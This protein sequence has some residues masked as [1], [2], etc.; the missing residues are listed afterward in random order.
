MNKKS[1]TG[2]LI[3]SKS[4]DCYWTYHRLNLVLVKGDKNKIVIAHQ[5]DKIVILGN[6]NEIIV[7]ITG[8]IKEIN[9][10]GNNNAIFAKYL[11]SLNIN[12]DYGIG[13][14]TYMKGSKKESKTQNSE[15]EEE[16]EDEYEQE[17]E[18]EKK[19][20]EKQEKNKFKINNTNNFSINRNYNENDGHEE[21]DEFFDFCDD[22]SGL[23]LYE[24]SEIE[25]QIQMQLK[26]EREKE[27]FRAGIA[28]IVF[29][30]WKRDDN[31][32]SIEN[33]VLS[34]LI[35]ISFKNVSKGIKEGNEKCS[36]CLENFKEN[37]NVKMTECF[38][39]FHYKCI[40]EWIEC[41]KE[42]TEM[43]EC[44]ICRRKL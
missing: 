31:S 43:P 14:V 17:K 2:K 34:D 29:G 3:I 4:N 18:K 8:S 15:D 30:N 32:D 33:D 10:M 7:E 35:D 9:F 22:F 19:I 26:R 41:K 44:P 6:N 13:N 25:N 38:H 39:I 1:N 40:K 42:S 28:S 20:D 37:E 27:L 12:S 23:S 21:D 24:L 16:N 11:D 5:T 36:I